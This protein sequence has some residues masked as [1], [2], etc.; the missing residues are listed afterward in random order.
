[1]FKREVNKSVII[2]MIVDFFY[3]RKFEL[4]LILD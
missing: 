1:M 3:E 4:I 2:D